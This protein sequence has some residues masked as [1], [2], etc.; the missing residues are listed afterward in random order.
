MAKIEHRQR[1]RTIE[2]IKEDNEERARDYRRP[3]L[4]AQERQELQEALKHSQPDLLVK[5]PPSVKHSI[6]IVKDKA[7]LKQRLDYDDYDL[8]FPKEALSS[9]LF[10]DGQKPK[11]VIAFTP[12]G[13]RT[14]P[15]EEVYYLGKVLPQEKEGEEKAVFQVSPPPIGQIRAGQNILISQETVRKFGYWQDKNGQITPFN[16]QEKPASP[17]LKKL[18]GF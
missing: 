18:S 12:G 9:F 6:R 11:E 14:P 4:T 1:V 15:R 13:F 8:A 2:E 10:L 5:I 3:R 16:P 17:P 7:K